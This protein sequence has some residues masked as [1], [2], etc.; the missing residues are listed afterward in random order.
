M[1]EATRTAIIASFS[2]IIHDCLADMD[3]RYNSDRS[4]FYVSTVRDMMA[5][6]YVL[7]EVLGMTLQGLTSEVVE[8]VEMYHTEDMKNRG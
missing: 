7:A 8:A 1:D 3:D 6:R 5:E 4:E 2:A